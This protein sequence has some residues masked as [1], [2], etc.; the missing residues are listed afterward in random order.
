[1][2]ITID[3]PAGSGKSTAARNLARRLGAAFLDT[4]ATY[5]AATLR[6]LREGAEMNDPTALAECTREADIHLEQGNGELRVFLDGEDVSTDIRTSAVTDHVRYLANSPQ[7][8]DVLVEL[9]RR[10]GRELRDFV[11]EGRDQGS[12]VFP[13]ADVKFFL[14]ADPSVRAER[15][16]VEL[17]HAGEDVSYEAVLAAIE[18]RDRADRNRSV[19]P[20]VEPP[21]AIELDTT[22]LSPSETLARLE[23]HVREVCL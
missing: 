5:R 19:G 17:R 6:A 13:D 15:R 11:T 18:Q 22:H 10:I 8:R 1:M 2:I 4:G 16:L 12:V 14:K 20:L 23:Q 3:G 7:V 21:G 9:Q